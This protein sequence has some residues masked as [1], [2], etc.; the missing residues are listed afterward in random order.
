MVNTVL[1]SP[2]KPSMI[3]D[4]GSWIEDSYVD[5]KK[6]QNAPKNEVRA[7]SDKSQSQTSTNNS[8]IGLLILS[9]LI[10][11]IIFL[12]DNSWIIEVYTS[13][14]FGA[15]TDAKVYIQVTGTKGNTDKIWLEDEGKNNKKLFEKGSCDKFTRILPDIGVPKIL[16]IGHDNSGFGPGW[17]LEKVVY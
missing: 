15:G 13:E 5:P 1:A 17:H 6:A 10:N 3:S 2:K 14:V 11:F 9:K 4:D 8:R 12:V 7:F 16:K